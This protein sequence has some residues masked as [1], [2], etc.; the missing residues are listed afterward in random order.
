MAVLVELL[1]S[2][3]YLI[4][5][6]LINCVI[7]QRIALSANELHFWVFLRL[8]IIMG[9]PIKSMIF[10]SSPTLLIILFCV[11]IASKKKSSTYCVR[12]SVGWR[13]P[14]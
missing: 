1:A 6:S 8:H 11:G 7:G 5:F 10:L 2:F 13:P 12:L 4:L 3:G 9:G 14:Y